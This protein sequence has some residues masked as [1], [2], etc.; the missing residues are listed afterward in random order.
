MRSNQILS[1]SKTRLLGSLLCCSILLSCGGSG[2]ETSTTTA[3]I[4][5][6]GITYGK[7]TGFGSVFV[8]GIEFNT[9]ASRFDVDGS[10][11]SSQQEAQDG[12]LTIGMVVKI[13]GNKTLGI[14]DSVEY[15]DEVQGP[16]VGSNPLSATQKSFT[17]FGQT[18]VIDKLNT[19]FKNTD[20]DSLAD[21]DIVEVSGFRSSATDINATFVEKKNPGVLEVELKGTIS[22]FVPGSF[23][24]NL[25]GIAISFDNL[26]IIDTP[27]GT[28][29]DDLFVE[30]K[31]ILQPNNSIHATKIEFEDDGF[32]SEAS[33]VSLQGVITGYDPNTASFQINGQT[34]NASSA[35]RV[36]ANAVIGNGVNVEVEGNIVGGVLIADELKLREGSVEIKAF[37]DSFG[38]ANEII[39]TFPAPI[40][41]NISLITDGNTEF[42]DNAGAN[43]LPNLT[44]NDLDVGN[45]VEIKGFDTGSGII[46]NSVK[47]ENIE[48][49]QLEGRVESFILD[50][51]ITILGITYPVSLG[52][53]YFLFE[54]ATAT[55]ASPFFSQLTTGQVVEMT[56]DNPADGVADSVEK[57]N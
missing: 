39:I 22:G 33:N 23:N 6:T 17:V 19:S 34:V 43:P 2:G 48:D 11:F 24:F 54:G 20:F 30:V 46:V 49:T 21:T 4:G 37:I 31:G 7:I 56:D 14:A 47:R 28:L 13:T 53:E 26:T 29:T 5:G 41:G 27:G 52:T 8:N 1:S 9:D 55:T 15:D 18:V 51:S 3:G 36:P 12:G 42:V 38:A 44:F 16:V 50:T 35:I 10:P 40:A 25:G 57:K 32:E 45:F